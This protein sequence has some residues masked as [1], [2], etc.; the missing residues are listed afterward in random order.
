MTTAT[1]LGAREHARAQVMQG[2]Q[3]RVLVAKVEAAAAEDA[4][5]GLGRDDLADEGV[6]GRLGCG[7][8]AALRRVF[9]GP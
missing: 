7:L 3:R 9:H 4:I 1:T 6:V 5:V 2:V 8:I